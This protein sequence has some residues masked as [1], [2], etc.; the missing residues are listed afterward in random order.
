MFEN[1]ISRI[2]VNLRGSAMSSE[3]PVNC[4]FTCILREDQKARRT[5]HLPKVLYPTTAVRF[6]TPRL[7]ENWASG[8]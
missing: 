3:T 2:V 8:P 7:G 5:E 1:V 6:P 4:E